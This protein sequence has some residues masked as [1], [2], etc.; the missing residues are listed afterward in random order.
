M[1]Q[2]IYKILDILQYESI[3]ALIN[4]DKL[5][6]NI[7]KSSKLQLRFYEKHYEKFLLYG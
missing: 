7:I 1:V 4:K 5:K 3:N 2:H 6:E